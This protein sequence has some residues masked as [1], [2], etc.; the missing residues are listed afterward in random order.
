MMGAPTNDGNQ[1]LGFG[2]LSHR[3]IVCID[4]AIVVGCHE[5]KGHGYFFLRVP[6]PRGRDADAAQH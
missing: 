6:Q 1:L 4:T 3:C 5:E 2:F